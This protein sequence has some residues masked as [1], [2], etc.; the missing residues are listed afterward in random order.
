MNTLLTIFIVIGGIGILFLLISLVIGDL[1]ESLDFDF[2]LEF[3]GGDGG[4]F[5]VLDS[6]VISVFLTA[7]GGIGAVALQFGYG[8]LLSAIFGIGSGVALGALV[9][10]FGYFL[11][12]QQ[13]SSSVTERELVGRTAKVIVKIQKGTVGQ[14]SCRIGDASIEKL[15]RSRD[16]SEIKRGDTVFIE[17]VTADAFIVSPMENYSQIDE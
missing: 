10:A 13:A 7:F 14:I 8:G 2:D 12:T 9:F 1:F 4:S 11:H 3:D 6:R 16:G 15:A 17:E 5:G